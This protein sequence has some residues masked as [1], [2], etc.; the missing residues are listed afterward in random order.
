MNVWFSRGFRVSVPAAPLDETPQ[1]CG[2][3]RFEGL[4]I[5][6]VATHLDRIVIFGAL[7]QRLLRRDVFAPRTR[8]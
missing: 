3:L 2:V 7:V 1:K 5:G 8:F 4:G 6:R